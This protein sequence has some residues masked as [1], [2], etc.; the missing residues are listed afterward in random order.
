MI[1]IFVPYIAPSTNSI[2]AGIHYRTRMKHKELAR[3]AVMVAVAGLSPIKTKVDMSF[4]PR[5]GKGDR[6]RDTSNY[7]YGAKLIEDCIVES[8]LI[9][10]DTR[11]YVG[12][13]RLKELVIDR[14]NQS[15][16]IVQIQP[17]ANDKVVK[18]G[19]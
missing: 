11:K 7:S 19:E 8:G 1:E 15:G 16:V 5:L 9:G 14:K 17:R 13:I 12:D 18:H 6:E 2:Y 3:K 10:D 4:T